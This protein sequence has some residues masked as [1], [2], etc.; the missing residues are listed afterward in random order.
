[1]N[2]NAEDFLEEE[3]RSIEKDKQNAHSLYE[4]SVF[5][6][7]YIESTPE[8]ALKNGISLNSLDGEGARTDN[9]TML[10][11]KTLKVSLK[12]ALRQAMISHRFYGFGYILINTS[13]M[14]DDLKLEVNRDIPTGFTFLDPRKI[15]DNHPKLDK[16][17]IGYLRNV[18]SKDKDETNTNIQIHKSRLIMYENYDIILD[19]FVPVYSQG[20]LTGFKL[21][22]DIYRQIN[23]RI[24]NFTFLHYNDETLVE[25]MNSLEEMQEKA[26]KLRQGN[27]SFFKFLTSIGGGGDSDYTNNRMQS[28]GHTSVAL[29]Q[30]LTK[31]K[32]KLNNDGI[33]YT[34]NEKA[35]LEVVKYDLAFLKDAFELVKAK[36]GADT[37]EPLTRSFNEQVKGLGSDGKGD[38]TNYYDYLKS[39]QEA[40][41][42]AVNSK[43]NLHYNLDMKF[44]D[45]EVLSMKERV[46]QETLFIDAYTKYLTLI[47]DSRV[48]DEQAEYIKSNLS[49]LAK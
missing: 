48:K 15:V 21:F 42:I 9:T 41:E 46:E 24:G 31:I 11:A 39:V 35:R 6:R 5:F 13:G 34:S 47:K 22:E 8:D 12:S 4:Y 40:V 33:F 19:Q 2:K 16:P 45:I 49:I 10:L 1:M 7:N 28:L 23:K 25:L 29:E 18:Y 17:Y 44:N 27:N 43:L 3:K 36:I 20:L 30:E 32:D 37:K 26:N 14:D 38:R